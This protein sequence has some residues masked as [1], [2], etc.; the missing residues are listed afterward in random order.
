MDKWLLIALLALAPTSSALAASCDDNDRT[1]TFCER[2]ELTKDCLRAQYA[3]DRARYA[4]TA[5]SR[6]LFYLG[7]TIAQVEELAAQGEL[8]GEVRIKTRELRSMMDTWSA[9]SQDPNWLLA[10]EAGNDLI[11]ENKRRLSDLLRV[12]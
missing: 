11:L 8:N 2:V 3:C 10:V 5:F 9:T 1:E 12:P 4:G 7:A 6:A